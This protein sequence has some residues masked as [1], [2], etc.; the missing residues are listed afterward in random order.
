MP[1][2]TFSAPAISPAVTDSFT[3]SVDFLRKVQSASS[4]YTCPGNLSEAAYQ[5]TVPVE[6]ASGKTFRLPSLSRDSSK[7]FSCR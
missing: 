4:S 6:S 5:E 2:R 3:T 7:P 1:C